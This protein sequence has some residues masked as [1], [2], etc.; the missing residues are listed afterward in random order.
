MS[1]RIL[2]VGRNG[3]HQHDDEGEA[4]FYLDRHRIILRPDSRQVGPQRARDFCQRRQR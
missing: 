1:Q 2:I 3:S 4:E